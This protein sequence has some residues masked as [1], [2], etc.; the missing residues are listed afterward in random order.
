LAWKAQIARAQFVPP[1]Q[2]TRGV[3]RLERDATVSART[4]NPDEANCRFMTAFRATSGLPSARRAARA[5]RRDQARSQS[6]YARTRNPNNSM[7]VAGR[8]E[9]AL[10]LVR[11]P[12]ASTRSVAKR[13]QPD[14][15]AVPELIA[16][17]DDLEAA[18]GRDKLA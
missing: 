6:G 3:M 8:E 2:R 5:T 7:P 18:R 9:E 4:A 17:N 15:P 13:C 1:Q 10:D 16:T 14:V 12:L 11:E